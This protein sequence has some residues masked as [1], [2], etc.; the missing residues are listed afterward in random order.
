M[1]DRRVHACVIVSFEKQLRISEMHFRDAVYVCEE[2]DGG[3][4][5]IRVSYLSHSDTLSIQWVPVTWQVETQVSDVVR[6][7]PRRVYR[8]T[9]T[10]VPLSPLALVGE[11]PAVWLLQHENQPVG[12]RCEGISVFP[13]RPYAHTAETVWEYWVRLTHVPAWEWTKRI[14]SDVFRRIG[15]APIPPGICFRKEG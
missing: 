13:R 2:C 10:L 14:D 4:S 12:L 8:D 3:E 1:C 11:V 7:Q 6:A 15:R 9:Y 5:H